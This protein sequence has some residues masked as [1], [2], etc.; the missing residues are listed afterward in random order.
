MAATYRAAM[1]L[2]KGGHEAL[3][4]VELPFEPPRPG[5]PRIRVCA[6]GVA[7]TDFA[8]FNLAVP[9]FA[10]GRFFEV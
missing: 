2:K 6:A 3:R 9:R 4:V 8:L 7:S 10:P 5:Q 1:V